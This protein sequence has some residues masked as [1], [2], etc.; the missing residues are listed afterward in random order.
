[1]QNKQPFRRR[2]LI[3]FA[4]M[5]ILVS[6]VFSLS[7]VAIVHLIEE[8]LV[9][10]ELALELG[11]VVQQDLKSGQA[12]RLD[13]RTRFFAS[14]YPQYAIPQ[15]YADLPEGFSERL[16]GERAFYIF[17]EVINGDRYLLVQEQSDFEKREQ[18]LFN[19]VLAGFLLSVLGALVLGWLMSERVMRPV[20]KLA[21][22]VRHRDQLLPLAPA[23]APEY[24]DDEVGQLA[25]AFDSTLGRLRQSLER[26][27]LF[28]SDVSHELRT[29]LMVIASSCELLSQADLPPMQ[30]NQVQRIERASAEMQ[31]LVQTFLQLARVKGNESLFAGS[32]S[33]RQITDE[34]VETWAPLMREKGLDFQLEVQAHNEGVYNPTLLRTVMANLLRNAL[35]YTETGFVK[36]TLLADGFRVEDSGVGIPE[37]HHEQIF[38]PFVRGEQARGEGL[39]LGLSLVKRICAHQGW[40]ITV[41][42]LPVAGSCFQVVLQPT[43]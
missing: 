36:L 9:S 18:V 27:R 10:E 2:I 12:P 31:D 43:N 35:H 25:A 8:H 19:V 11:V 38:D 28:T 7:I 6:G 15:R 42:S 16:E 22:Q 34:Q 5:T 41:H 4:T 14:N 39:G 24:P 20:S 17:T 1:M 26:E 13:S 21:K 29:P 37:Q 40:Q 32:A 23:L 33:L 30:R 3:A